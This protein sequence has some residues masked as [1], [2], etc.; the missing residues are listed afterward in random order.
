MTTQYPLADLK[1]LIW[2]ALD[3]SLLSS[4]QKQRIKTVGRISS[5][6]GHCYVASEVAYYALGKDWQ[7]R[8]IRKS[9]LKNTTHWFLYN[10][11]THEIFDPTAEQFG[12]KPIPYDKAVNCAFLTKWPSKRAMKVLSRMADL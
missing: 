9:V 11:R 3:D 2:G 1:D 6:D 5:V 10:K 8:V 12:D 4:E 7:P